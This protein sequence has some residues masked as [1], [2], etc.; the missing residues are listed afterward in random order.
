MNEKMK[1]KLIE[2][3]FF[4]DNFCNEKGSEIDTKLI[5]ENSDAHKMSCGLSMSEIMTIE[6]FYHLQ[7]SKCFK[8]YYTYFV[9]VHLKEY[10]PGLVSY[11][12]FVQL[13]P[14][15]ML[16]MF[17]FL[18]AC[19]LGQKTDCYFIDS[20]KI[21]VCHN[22]RINSNRVF[23]NIA[24]RGKTSTGWFYG[25][26]LHLVINEIGEIIS[27]YLTKGNVADNNFDL[28]LKLCK[29]LLGKIYGDKGYINE[30]LQ[31]ELL[32]QDLLLVTKLKKNM[33]NKF[34][35]NEDKMLLTKRGVIESVNDIL[36]NIC[37]IE[38]S[39]HRSPINA[40]INIFSGLIAYSFLDHKPSVRKSKVTSREYI[41]LNSLNCKDMKLLAA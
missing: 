39:R 7:G 1:F 16:Y 6:I 10:F 35:K 40:F 24:K 14:R 2:I 4:S 33:K 23:K 38:H 29:G 3:F 32:K 9:M 36:K 21:A 5:P 11:N 26:K 41:I 37:D 15:M 27:C 31:Q 34:V 20:T 19:R 8:Y 22:L 13:K 12:R 30:K 18:L 28:G 25:I 17:C